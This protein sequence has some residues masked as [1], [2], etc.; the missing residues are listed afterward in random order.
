MA[1]PPYP[2][3]VRLAL[4]AALA[5]IV[6]LGAYRARSLTREGALA[7]VVVGSL[8]VGAGWAWGALLVAYFVATSMLSAIRGEERSRRTGSIVAKGGARDATQVAANGGVF[9][10]AAL[11]QLL[12]PQPAWAAIGAGALAAAAADSWATELGTLAS[13]PPRHILTLRPVPTGTSGGVSAIGS[14]ASIAGGAFI[15]IVAWMLGWP[16]GTALA[17]GIAGLAGSLA[18][19]L[20]GATVQA[21]RRCERCGSGTERIV[22]RCGGTTRL[23]GGVAWLDN[24]LVNLLSTVVGAA[25]AVALAT[26]IGSPS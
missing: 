11:G 12:L 2:P 26:A 18:D 1:E 6:A 14:T 19:S 15:A 3:T 8:A 23:V 10:L 9:G 16:P 25:V 17:A 20:L 5:V 21:R 7:A 22:H 24:D 13:R 4:G